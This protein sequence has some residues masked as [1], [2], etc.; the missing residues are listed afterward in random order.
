MRQPQQQQQ[1]WRHSFKISSPPRNKNSWQHAHFFSFF[2]PPFDLIYL[3]PKQKK[4]KS[5]KS[6]TLINY[7]EKE[8]EK[9]HTPT[10]QGAIRWRRKIFHSAYL[11]RKPALQPVSCP[12]H[13]C[14]ALGFVK[15][16][17]TNKTNKQTNTAW[18]NTQ[19]TEGAASVAVCNLPRSPGL[20]S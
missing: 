13:C 14:S 4:K 5:K 2:P 9:S 15:K 12:M 3:F 1:K 7:P 16:K 8:R 18:H 6:V 19:W 11:Q 20:T 10:A 17:T